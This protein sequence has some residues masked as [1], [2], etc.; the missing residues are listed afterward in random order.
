MRL[1]RFL[2]TEPTET[3]LSQ[4]LGVAEIGHPGTGTENASGQSSKPGGLGCHTHRPPEG[5]R[6]VRQLPTSTDVGD[7]ALQR[8]GHSGLWNAITASE[9]DGWQLPS[10][11]QPIHGHL[12]HAHQLCNLSN[13]E[14]SDVWNL[15]HPTYPFLDVHTLCGSWDACKPVWPM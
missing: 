15:G 7:R 13:G 12:G 3:S 11:N 9:T 5:C 10:M 6:T 8:V 14:E 2:M 1:R 4:W